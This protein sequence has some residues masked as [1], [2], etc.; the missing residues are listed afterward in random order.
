[1]QPRLC[2][3]FVALLSR[4]SM[5]FFTK[6]EPNSDVNNAFAKTEG[7]CVSSEGPIGTCADFVGRCDDILANGASVRTQCP[8]MCGCCTNA[9]TSQ[10]QC[11][12]DNGIAAL[13]FN[14]IGNCHDAASIVDCQNQ[15]Y[16]PVL[17]RLCPCY[18]LPTPS[19]SPSPT[20]SPSPLQF[21]VDLAHL[22]TSGGM[23]VQCCMAGDQCGASVSNIGDF[24]ND[25]K[26]DIIIGAPR[27]S[28]DGKTSVGEAYIVFG[29]D[30]L[31]DVL[32]L[33]ALGSRGVVIRGIDAGDMCGHAVSGLGD[34]N[35]DGVADVVVSASRADPN[36]NLAAG[37]SYVI[38][39]G[40]NVGIVVDL[41]QLG[42]KGVVI[43][44]AA[45]DDSSGQTVS[46]LGDVNG[47][48]VGDIL[49]GAHLADVNNIQNAG[50]SYVIYGSQ[51]LPEIVNV[52][53][54]DG[55]NGVVLV[56]STR[57]EISSW[58]ASGGGD[59]NGDG[60]GDILIGAHRSDPGGRRDAGEVFVVYG[61][62]QLP[63]II[64]LG[65]LGAEGA[66]IQG[67]DQR[68]NAGYSVSWAGDINLDGKDDIIIGA[69]AANE[70]RG[71]TYIVYGSSTFPTTFA[72]SSLLDN[73]T[74]NGFVVVG[75]SP[76]DRSGS[77]V[78]GAGDV[79]G[80]GH[81]DFLIGARFA[82]PNNINNAGTAYIIYGGSHLDDT[83]VFDINVI[84]GLCG[85]II[86]GCASGD[87][88]GTAVSPAG[89]FNNDGKDDVVI[90]APFATRDN[91]SRVGEAFVVF[92]I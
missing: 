77:A 70:R 40:A 26:D 16:G 22:E 43:N 58:V 47:D 42:G 10:C 12:D 6:V 24:N 7:P 23:V 90:G 73:D 48:G 69:P 36:G 13:G 86:E 8:N 32:D 44:G 19:T 59:L 25:G 80:D 38:F 53:S 92:G 52:T 55:S 65:S 46:G 71:E 5:A 31:P 82:D 1:M 37:E 3:L 83:T 78:S 39:G 57:N 68:D 45:M 51:S 63:A 28:R 87:F 35:G 17:R 85:L 76:N 54:L 56:G 79:N 27:A 74:N 72:L 34:V 9:L 18:C 84:D 61:G 81:P 91:G 4:D 49:V 50:A 62:P 29:D 64:D 15:Q 67:I 30:S 21:R 89:D 14:G 60:I 11:N 20:P 88:L 66:V 75:N 41:A 33:S 2:F